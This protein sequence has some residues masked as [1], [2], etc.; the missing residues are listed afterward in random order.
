MYTH[1]FSLSLYIF[2]YVLFLKRKQ[3][4]KREEGSGAAE[5]RWEKQTQS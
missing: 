5:V 4:G 1:D 2:L 3:Y